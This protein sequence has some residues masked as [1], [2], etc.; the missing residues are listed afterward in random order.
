M[1]A[2]ALC[3]TNLGCVGIQAVISEADL[4]IFEM[5]DRT[6]FSIEA[7]LLEAVALGRRA[8]DA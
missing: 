3:Q 6:A 5:A 8:A 7:G 2:P 1:D 4:L